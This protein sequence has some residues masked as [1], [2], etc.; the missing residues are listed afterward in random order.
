MSQHP[1]LSLEKS[2]LPLNSNSASVNQT[3][4]NQSNQ[5]WARRAITITIWVL[6]I[7]LLASVAHASWNAIAK[8]L[9]DPSFAF[10]WINLTVA[11]IGACFIIAIGLPNRSALPFL[12][13]SFIIHIA[14][15]IFLLNSYRF[16]DLSQVYP[17]A[18]GIAPILVA[19]GAFLFAGEQLNAIEVTGIIVIAAALASIAEF[20]AT[21][22][23]WLS[24]ATG[25]A[26]GGYSLVDGIGVRHAHSSFA[27]AGL[28]FLLEGGVLGIG[29]GW[30]RIRRQRPLITTQLPLAVTAGALSYLAYAAVL[31][32]QQRAPLG[33]VSA[34]RETSVIVAALIGGYF[35]NEELGRRRLLAAVIVCIG[36][37]I[38]VL[39]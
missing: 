12:L 14:Y 38:L 16:G 3:S 37:T 9:D 31:W 32:A 21:K 18:R 4:V 25:L 26:I 11:V 17:L 19:I 35:L 7:V 24:L 23:L 30:M 8:Y 22:A 28:L 39:S 5:R 34:L 10:V 1:T 33:V 15:N 13:V 27:Y 29:I 6:A 20:H 2:Y 36:V